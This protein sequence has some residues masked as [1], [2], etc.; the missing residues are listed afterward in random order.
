MKKN[1]FGHY[2]VFT[3]MLM[4]VVATLLIGALCY[5]FLGFYVA[6]RGIIRVFLIIA[7]CYTTMR[8]FMY[9]YP[10]LK[11]P[12]KEETP[13]KGMLVFWLSFSCVEVLFLSI[14]SFM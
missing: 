8:I 7:G 4:G 3:G 2:P 1:I 14:L 11:K 12:I 9:F 13:L 10:Q 6:I 5:K